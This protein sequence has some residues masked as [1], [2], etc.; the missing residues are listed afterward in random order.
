MRLIYG[1]LILYFLLVAG[2]VLA[3]W[4][5]GVLWRIPPLW[6]LISAVVVVGLGLVLVVTATPSTPTR[7]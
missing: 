1:Y 2:A 4:Q 6:L 5:A 3:L 7:N